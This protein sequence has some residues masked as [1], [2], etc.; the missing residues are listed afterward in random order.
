MTPLSTSGSPTP[1]NS[2]PVSENIKKSVIEWQNLRNKDGLRRTQEEGRQGEPHR[3]PF[4]QLLIRSFSVVDNK[5]LDF[6]KLL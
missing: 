6:Q 5:L 2:F 1:R 3:F 4:Q